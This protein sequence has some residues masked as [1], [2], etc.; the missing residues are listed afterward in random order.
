MKGIDASTV[1]TA[2]VRALATDV[3]ALRE[4]DVMI[5]Q[6]LHRVVWTCVGAGVAISTSTWGALITWT[7]VR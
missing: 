3:D 7:L 5:R 4:Q 6:L 2:A 1:N